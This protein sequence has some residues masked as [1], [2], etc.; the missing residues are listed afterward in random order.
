M[1]PAMPEPRPARKAGGRLW[2][3]SAARGR[4]A[5]LTSPR[6]GDRMP[7]PLPPPW[8][9]PTPAPAPGAPPRSHPPARRRGDR[10]PPAR[11]R[12]GTGARGGRGGRARRR[13]GARGGGWARGGGRRG[14]RGGSRDVRGERRGGRAPPLFTQRRL[15]PLSQERSERLRLSTAGVSHP[16][17]RLES[18][19]SGV[20]SNFFFCG[21]SLDNCIFR[22]PPLIHFTHTFTH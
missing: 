16:C 8:R 19:K 22:G 10:A 15:P 12:R 9:S 21:N 3:S 1:S 5:A 18:G 4:R 7:P 17:R 13:R 20:V 2:A 14:A 11:I 6:R